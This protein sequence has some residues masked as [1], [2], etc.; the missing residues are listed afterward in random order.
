MLENILISVICVGGLSLVFGAVL[1]LSAK[2]FAVKPDPVAEK[3]LGVLPGANCGGCGY[4]GCLV[5]AGHVA[6]GE[7]SYKGC[8][9]AGADGAVKIAEIIG[10]DVS[11]A[12]RKSAY[13]K[14]SGTDDDTKRNYF[15]DGPKSCVAA[16]QLA[17]GGNKSCS[18]SCV[19][20]AS[21][22]H[23]CP[24]DAIRMVNGVAVIDGKK[25]TACG[26]CIPACPKHLIE[27]AP[28]RCRVRVLCNSRDR[29]KV[30]KAN[31]RA[32]C[33][34]CRICQKQCE[35]GAVTV[36]DNIARINYGKCT[37]CMHCVEKC[38]SKV[39][40]ITPSA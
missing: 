10:L 4:P 5:F 31:C 3:V 17:T 35:T 2:K 14:C 27:I 22:Q 26:K 13:V 19:G 16:S 30:V 6:A 12:A 20:L 34:G 40:V 9:A 1:G 37:M 18:Y 38:P 15:Y 23:V 7:A 25:C 36:T 21:C 11:P 32:G 39:I 29:A 8:P 28:D 33:F 24:F